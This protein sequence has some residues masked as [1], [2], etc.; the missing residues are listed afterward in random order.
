MNRWIRGHSFASFF[1]SGSSVLRASR[2]QPNPASL[3]LRNSAESRGQLP[4]HV[5]S[6]FA[7]VF[8]RNQRSVLLLEAPG[9]GKVAYVAIGATVSCGLVQGWVR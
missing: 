4:P 9:Y 2:Q 6:P 3:L 5:R 7:N 1:L 8:T